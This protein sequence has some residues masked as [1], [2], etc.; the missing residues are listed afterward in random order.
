[1]AN[2]IIDK[3]QSAYLPRRS[4]DTALT[5]IINHILIYLDNQALCYLVLLDLSSAFDTLD[6]NIIYIRINEIGIYGQV[7]IWF[8]YFVLSRKS[9]VK[10]NS[11]LY[12]P[13]FNIHYWPY[14]VHYL[15]SSY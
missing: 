5:M 9:S 15:Y 3:Y 4:T 10:I 1:M 14:I 7:H 8:M 12:P 13:Y 6:H 11:L 2:A